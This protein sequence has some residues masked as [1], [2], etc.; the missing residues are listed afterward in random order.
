MTVVHRSIIRGGKPTNFPLLPFRGGML[1]I[2]AM[3]WVIENSKHSLGSF[4]VLLMIANH[5]KSDGTGA[6][7]SVSTLAR[8]ARMSERQVRNCLRNLEQSGE[9]R[10]AI[11][12]GP[13]GA[14]LYE[15][16]LM[17]GANI[18][19]VKISQGQI[20]TGSLSKIA[21]EPS[22]N[23]PTSKTPL[24]PVNGGREPVYYE[25]YGEIVEVQMG[26]RR[27]LPSQEGTQG[28]RAVD[29]AQV[30]TSRGYPSKVVSR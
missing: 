27:R 8:E 28:L 14:N 7:P 30:F 15:L 25:R 18:A 6:W 21:P 4:V 17:T 12:A 20:L 3:S 23:R 9:L 26:N 11:G 24:P 13:H 19:D 1:S 10:A 5:A 16:P 29:L 2:Q 22:F